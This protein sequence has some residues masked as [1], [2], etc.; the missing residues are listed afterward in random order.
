MKYLFFLVL[1]CHGL[2]A[3]NISFR[4]LNNG[5]P[6]N[7]ECSEKAGYLWNKWMLI[8]ELK[9]SKQKFAKLSQFV[10]QH[11]IPFK[12]WHLPTEK[13]NEDKILWDSHCK[14]HRSPQKDILLADIFLKN[15]TTSKTT[16]Y[17]QAYMIDNSGKLISFK[18]P[19]DY[20]PT[21][22]KNKKLIF[23]MEEEG[24]YYSLHISD[25][26]EFKVSK[27]IKSEQGIYEVRC[28]KGLIENF[29]KFEVPENLYTSKFCH[30][31]WNA[32]KNKFSTILMGWSCI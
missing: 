23:T 24:H 28:P 31:I 3:E 32:D 4:N 7:S 19:R 1:F 17:N 5:C 16:I 22:I 13:R 6:L 30:S 8:L 11:G 18:T 27:P 25:K 26:D 10:K 9:D 2:Q 12:T 21:L 15:L 14:N 29:D 20:T